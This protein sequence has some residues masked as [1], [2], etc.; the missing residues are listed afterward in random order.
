[1]N[2]LIYRSSFLSSHIK[3]NWERED[4]DESHTRQRV[5]I[6]HSQGWVKLP[7]CICH[8]YRRPSGLGQSV[9]CHQGYPPSSRHTRAHHMVTFCHKSSP[10]QEH[11]QRYIYLF[12]FGCFRTLYFN[13]APKKINF[14]YLCVI[15]QKKLLLN[16]VCILE[17]LHLATVFCIYYA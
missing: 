15:I 11:L 4:Q 16:A 12:T 1:M 14:S 7:T 13:F 6:V 10:T 2:R 9:G 3:L 8:R 5:S 17:L